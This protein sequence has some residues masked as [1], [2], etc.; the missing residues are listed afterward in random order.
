MDDIGEDRTLN[1]SSIKGEDGEA[2]I[3]NNTLSVSRIAPV[4]LIH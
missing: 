3:N 1:K 4:K 2:S